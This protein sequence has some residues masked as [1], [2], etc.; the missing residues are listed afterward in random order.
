MFDSCEDEDVD[1]GVRH[2]APPPKFEVL[3]QHHEAISGKLADWLM[4]FRGGEFD[5]DRMLWLMKQGTDPVNDMLR[6]ARIYAKAC[7]VNQGLPKPM[8]DIYEVTGDLWDLECAMRW[9]RR[10]SQGTIEIAIAL[11]RRGQIDEAERVVKRLHPSD[12]PYLQVYKA[13]KSPF[14]YAGACHEVACYEGTTRILRCCELAT[15]SGKPKDLAPAFRVLKDRLAD[16]RETNQ[17]RASLAIALSTMGHYPAARTLLKQVSIARIA[18][19]SYMR[20]WGRSG[21]I[22]DFES[23]EAWAAKAEGTVC[24]DEEQLIAVTQALKADEAPAAL[25]FA[26]AMADPWMKVR[27]LCA[28]YRETADESVRYE[29]GEVACGINH[30]R[31][32]RTMLERSAAQLEVIR[33]VCETC[34]GTDHCEHIEDSFEKITLDGFRS[35][36]YLALFVHRSKAKGLEV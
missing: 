10:R 28:Y 13:V 4:K 12:E 21:A 5:P 17:A 26:R 24:R 29:A 35:Q 11:A 27:A 9:G 20:L 8:C 36:A 19:S 33:A 3:P 23:A 2:K 18:F 14:W 34:D 30:E 31:F 1:G 15:A 6:L 7:L 22:E 25:G 32:G 16:D